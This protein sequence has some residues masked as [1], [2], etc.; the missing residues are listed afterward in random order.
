MQALF[1]Q[2]FLE[3]EFKNFPELIE[4]FSRYIRQGYDHFASI[5]NLSGVMFFLELN[6]RLQ[7]ILNQ[8]N[9][10]RLPQQLNAR[11][12]LQSLLAKEKI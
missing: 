12:E 6:E 5:S 2:D 8:N 11:S 10:D 3:N 1:K 4:P 7:K 9:Y